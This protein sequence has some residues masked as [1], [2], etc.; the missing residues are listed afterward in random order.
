MSGAHVS[1]EEGPQGYTF[2]RR[3]LAPFTWPTV[4][5][6]SP[7][8][9]VLCLPHTWLSLGP[10]T[11]CEQPLTWGGTCAAP[12][13][14][15]LMLGPDHPAKCSTPTQGPSVL[16]TSFPFAPGSVG[17][18]ARTQDRR[19]LS[20]GH[21]ELPPALALGLPWWDRGGVSVLRA[22][23]CW[24]SSCMGRHPLSC[25]SLGHPWPSGT[26]LPWEARLGLFGG[27]RAC[28]ML[29][30][31]LGGVQAPLCSRLVRGHQIWDPGSA[32]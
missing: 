26:V 17:C 19:A 12:T 13:S 8:V 2:S 21:L 20:W 28:P 27:C 25:P 15:G 23:T 30:C 31:G 10:Q 3:G 7:A 14:A 1:R 16:S 6:G 32:Q 9:V 22:A 4:D 11:T 5:L 29:A 24:H 18:W